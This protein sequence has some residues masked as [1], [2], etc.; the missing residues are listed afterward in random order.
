MPWFRSQ[1]AG[2]SRRTIHEWR[3]WRS[4]V[5]TRFAIELPVPTSRA[6][7]ARNTA[8]FVLVPPRFART[9]RRR[10]TGTILVVGGVKTPWSTVA[11]CCEGVFVRATVFARRTHLTATES[12][13]RF[14]HYVQ[15]IRCRTSGFGSSY[16]GI[17]CWY[18]ITEC[19]LV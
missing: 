16:N 19:C 10:K 7:W 1:R 18:I 17:S 3:A 5:S 2:C 6:T 15:V 12:A 11:A 13:A 8:S 4:T 9:T 14:I